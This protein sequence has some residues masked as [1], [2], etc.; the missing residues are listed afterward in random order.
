MPKR[1]YYY[2][3]PINENWKKMQKG[4]KWVPDASFGRSDKAKMLIKSFPDVLEKHILFEKNLITEGPRSRPR[5][6]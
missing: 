5:H 3:S 2:A 4:P 1:T 6:Q